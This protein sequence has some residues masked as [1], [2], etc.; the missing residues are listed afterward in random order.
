[1]QRACRRAYGSRAIATLVGIGIYDWRCLR[2]A[3]V[4][5]HVVPVLLVPVERLNITEAAFVTA[6]L[7]RLGTLMGGIRRFYQERTSAF[8]RGTNVFV[9]LTSTSA[10]DWQN[11]ALCTD[12]DACQYIGN[13]LPF[14][15]F[16]YANRIKQELKNG[17]WNIILEHSSARVAGFVTLGSSPPQTP[18]WCG[19]AE[20][21]GK[22]I[23]TA[24]SN[25]YA[26]CSTTINNPPD[27]EDAFYGAGHELGHAM[28][29]PH[30]DDPKCPN[31]PPVYVY[32]DVDPT[33][34]LL[35][36]SN[37]KDSI[38]CLGK[39]TASELFPFEIH[40]LLPFLLEWK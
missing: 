2:P 37:L 36:P 35:R 28:G 29:L 22:Y 19:A 21:P 34:N 1:M 16:G 6:A 4:S 13:P 20:L 25:S 11:L 5:G 8:V 30:S 27:Y 10:P 26:T 3:D 38:M 31:M 12:Q 9:L 39:G 17:R 40:R 7:Q 32:N 23:V 33:S 24:P 15:R 18:T 14:D